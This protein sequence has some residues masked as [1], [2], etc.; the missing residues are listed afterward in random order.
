[1][2]LTRAGRALEARVAALSEE[3]NSRDAA[4]KRTIQ[5]LIDE[6]KELEEQM[7]APASASPGLQ[8]SPLQGTPQRLTRLAGTPETRSLRLRGTPTRSPAHP[9]TPS[10]RDLILGDSWES[11]EAT[12]RMHYSDLY[13]E[14][15]AVNMQRRTPA[16]PARQTE[17]QR[18]QTLSAF[19]RAQQEPEG[20]DVSHHLMQCHRDWWHHQ[21]QMLM[22][23]VERQ[24]RHIDFSHPGPRVPTLPRHQS[25]QA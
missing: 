10:R 19:K 13:P 22:K 8:G 24:V 6:T 12:R 2:A 1:M 14:D 23:E 11:R 15:F 5:K 21:R 16:K 18:D 20:N 17:C 25:H 7:Q 9:K 4:H 3:M